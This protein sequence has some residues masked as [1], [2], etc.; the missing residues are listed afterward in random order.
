MIAWTDN[1]S[2]DNHQHQSDDSDHGSE[3]NGSEYNGS[4]YDE[5]AEFRWLEQMDGEVTLKERNGSAQIGY[6]KCKLIRRARMRHVFY[7]EMEEP[8]C[9]TSSLAFDIFDRYGRLRKEFKTH[10]IK[11]GTGLWQHELDNGDL[12]LFEEL[13][14]DKRYRRRGLGKRL[15]EAVLEKT[16]EKSESFFALVQPG[17]LYREV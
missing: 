9:E 1:D 15:V 4:E 14:I 17:Y 7:D 6:C 13:K 3:Y 12:L 11:R 2:R 5:F 10:P 16:C 8:S